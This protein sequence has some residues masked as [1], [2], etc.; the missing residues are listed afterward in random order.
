ML[1]IGL[2]IG[3][4][5]VFLLGR[6]ILDIL[7]SDNVLNMLEIVSLS[8]LIGMG[9]LTILLFVLSFFYWPHKIIVLGIIIT[10]LYIWQMRKK[11]RPAFLNKLNFKMISGID[12][13]KAIWIIL[14]VIIAIKMSYSLVEATS[15]PEY[16]WDAGSHWAYPGKVIY[17]LS[18]RGFGNIPD[19]LIKFPDHVCHYPKF[20]PYMHYWLFS[21]MGQDNDQWSRIF[22]PMVLFCFAAIF[23]SIIRKN[24]GPIEALFFLWIL[25]SGPLFIYHSTFGYADFTCSSYFSIGILM[26]Y[27][28][29]R[30]KKNIYFYLYSMFMSLT[31][32]IKLEGR[33]LYLIGLMLLLIY[34]WRDYAQPPKD[35]LIKISQYL[36]A[37]IILALPWQLFLSLNKVA[38]L[39][40]FELHLDYFFNLCA[41]F[42]GNLFFDGS[43]GVVWIGIIAALIF[44]YKELFN[45]ENKY[46][47]FTLLLFHGLFFTTYLSFDMY[48]MSGAAINRQWL[49]IYPVAVFT[50][51]CITPH[52]ED[53]FKNK[54]KGTI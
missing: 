41:S 5:L 4:A 7:D 40:N 2:F 17:G 43:W 14:L 3:L 46:L 51:A 38:P 31:P 8:F 24:K 26:F 21:W 45:C 50:V 28:W 48:L 13:K 1:Y 54:Q 18:Q 34:L 32:W 35:K 15:K 36:G 52:F 22:F 23:Y 44:F 9:A 39:W 6:V 16:S 29:A 11:T 47:F 30:D 37:Y 33:P 27:Q 19:I 42:Y 53:F 25:L 20:I 12:L 10:L 49:N